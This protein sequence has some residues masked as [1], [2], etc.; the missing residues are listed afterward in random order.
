MILNPIQQIEIESMV[1]MK[2]SFVMAYDYLRCAIHVNETHLFYKNIK[3]NIKI[4][5]DAIEIYKVKCILDTNEHSGLKQ[6]L[7]VSIIDTRYYLGL[8]AE[9][10][11]ENAYQQEQ[12]KFKE[13][14]ALEKPLI[15]SHRAELYNQK[16]TRAQ[17]IQN[18]VHMLRSISETRYISI[19]NWIEINRAL[20]VH[21][22]VFY[23]IE[24]NNPYL[25]RIKEKYPKNIK[26]IEYEHNISEICANRARY[27]YAI[28]ECKKEYQFYFEI[29]QLDYHERVNTNACLMHAKFTHEFMTN[30]DIGM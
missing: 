6:D 4:H 1:L 13:N 11:N 8:D 23:T 25:S 3:A 5:A 19:L 9:N 21:D 16:T 15:F 2:E 26:I 7:T 18:C 27:G 12:V 10:E 20:G 29:E 24:H 14:R 22:I 30:F 17:S 28:E